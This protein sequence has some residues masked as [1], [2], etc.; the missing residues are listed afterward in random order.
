MEKKDLI[1]GNIYS[2]KWQRTSYLVM[3]IVGMNENDKERVYAEYVS[4]CSPSYEKKS[5]PYLPN[6]TI[7]EA[8]QDEI[9][10][11]LTAREMN[12]YVKF[13]DRKSF[14]PKEFIFEI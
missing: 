8:T 13:E 4:N 12:D 11:L 9:D 5:T 14:A 3:C 7:K 2:M 10:W 6:R 1:I